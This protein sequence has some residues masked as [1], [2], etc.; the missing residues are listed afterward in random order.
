M[1]EILVVDDSKMNQLVLKNILQEEYN[2]V[3]ASSGREMFQLLEQISPKLIL[4]DVIMPELDG[5]EIIQKLKASEQYCKIPVI[6]ITGLDDSASEEKGFMLGA[7]DYI[8]K[9]FKENVVRARVRS[10]VQLYDFIRQTEMMG[11]NDGLTGL[12]NKKMTEMQIKKQLSADPPLK[13]GALMIIDIDNFK[14]INDTFGHIYGDAVITQMGSALRVIFQKSDI[15]GRVGGDEFFVFLRNYNDH[16]ILIEL[17]ERLCENFR[18]TYEQN[19]ITVS[20][21]ASVGIAT[22]EDSK[23]FEELYTFADLALYSTKARGKNGYTLYD[24]SQQAETYKSTRTEI[25]SMVITSNDPI[26]SIKELKNSLIDHAF[27]VSGEIELTQTTLKSILQMICGQFS[28]RS[29]NIT[30]FGYD[31]GVSRCNFNWATSDPSASIYVKDIDFTHLAELYLRSEESNLLIITKNDP[32]C[33]YF[34]ELCGEHASCVFAIKNK[35][36]LLGYI[37]FELEPDTTSLSAVTINNITDI[38]QQ[39]TPVIINQLMLEGV[40]G[41][42][43]NLKTLIDSFDTPIYVARPEVYKPLFENEA[44]KNANITYHGK[45]CYK[46]TVDGSAACPNCPMIAAEQ[47]GGFYEDDKHLCKRITWSGDIAAYAITV[48]G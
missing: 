9:P 26:D 5:F 39:I 35:S 43:K 16:A 27:D 30:K 11:Q 45:A 7:I 15:L 47:N 3:C 21:S 25:E 46:K 24:P 6:F 14:S 38:C 36:V 12:Y 48:K 42:K 10:Y 22:I 1:D 2:V 34:P 17:A 29:G 4:L 33:T 37:A 32:L 18:K 41:S 13:S 40:V 19:G 8:T 28:F 31:D 23:N 44:S 20:V